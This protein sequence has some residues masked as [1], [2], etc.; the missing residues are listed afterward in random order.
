MH[1]LGLPLLFAIF[2]ASLL[3]FLSRQAP[4]GPFSK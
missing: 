2:A 4:R 3:G 1:P